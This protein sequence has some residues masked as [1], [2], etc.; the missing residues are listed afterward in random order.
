M[1]EGAV[2]NLAGLLNNGLSVSS[3]RD[4]LDDKTLQLKRCCLPHQTF[5]FIFVFLIGAKV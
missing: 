4:T 5:G 3:W 2:I 1:V